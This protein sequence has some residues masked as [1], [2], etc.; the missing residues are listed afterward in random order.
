MVNKSP[1]GKNSHNLRRREESTGAYRKA[2]WLCVK[3]NR[4][5]PGHS[6][7]GQS[8]C[9]TR[10]QD[11]EYE[12]NHREGRRDRSRGLVSLSVDYG[13]NGEHRHK[14]LGSSKSCFRLRI[15]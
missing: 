7:R 9:K 4:V 2:A 1:R 10:P 3:S 6:G 11:I 12:D 15:V 8:P 13:H 14:G 5:V